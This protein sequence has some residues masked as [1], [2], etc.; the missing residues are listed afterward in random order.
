MIVDFNR[1][2]ALGGVAV[3][4]LVAAGVA[5]PVWAQDAKAPKKEAMEE[6]VV[7]GS[8]IKRPNLTQPVPVQVFTAEAIKA[9]GLSS[10]IDVIAQLP[11]GQNN[12]TSAVST[13]FINGAGVNF[14]N[15]RGLGE[16]R[17]LT[18][19]DGKRHVGSLGGRNN[20]GGTSLVDLNAIAPSMI[21]RIDIVTGGTSAVY[22][23]DAVAG[24][25]NVILKKNF[26]G[27]ELTVQHNQSERAGFESTD[28]N[29]IIGTNFA[30][31]RGNITFAFDRN[32]DSGL[33]G[34]DRDQAL[35]NYT[36]VAN[37][38]NTG[39][40][41]GIPDRITIAPT[42]SSVLAAS[43]SPVIKT[44]IG[45]IA[46][47]TLAFKTDGSGLIPFNRG[48]L[49]NPPTSATSAGDTNSLGGDGYN[50]SQYLTLR[51][52][53]LRQIGQVKADYEI[54]R[55][56]GPLQ[57]IN[58]FA[59]AKF[60]DSEGFTRSTP[61]ANGTGTPGTGTNLTS[62]T[63]ALQISSDNPYI[64]SDLSALLAANKLTSFQM[65][66]VNADWGGA[67][68][69]SFEY[70]VARVVTGFNGEL[71]NGWKW[72]AFYNYG[73]NRT[74]FI[75]T[76][77][78]QVNLVQ[79]LDAIKLADGSIVCRDTTARA[80]GCVP[81]NPFKVGPLT[82]AQYN[83]SYVFTKEQ[84][85]LTQEDV[86]FNFSGDLLTYSTLFSGTKAPIGFAAGF[87]RRKETTNDKTDPLANQPTGFIYGNQNGSVVGQYAVN[88]G[89][90]ELSVPLL[91]DLPFVK[92]LDLDLA[93]RY[94][95]YTTAGPSST[96]N[97]QGGWAVNDSVKFRS[98]LARAVRAPNIDDLFSPAG[99]NFLGVSDPCSIEQINSGGAAR[100]ANCKAVVP[101]GYKSTDF[102]NPSVRTG[103]NPAL[104]PEIGTTFTAG[105]VLTPSF[106]PGLSATLDYWLVKIRNGQASLDPNSILRNCYDSGV[107]AQCGLIQR[108]ADG[109]IFR[110]NGTTVNIGR[111]KVTGYD[112]GVTY[113]FNLDRFGL[114]YIGDFRAGFDGSYVPQSYVLQN[115]AQLTSKLYRAGT[116]GYP[117]LKGN[118]RLNWEKGDL[119]VTYSGRFIGESQMF[120]NAAPDVADFSKVPEYWYHDISAKYRWRMVTFFG[121]INNL[122]DKMPPALPFLYQ[123]S[124]QGGSYSTFPV[125]TGAG[126]SYD[127]V[128]R[129]F[130]FG[131]TVKY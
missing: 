43:G 47:Y 104:K 8:R 49:I 72:E 111:E 107:A 42:V 70:Q 108:R 59:D 5:G 69:Y 25:V 85:V 79:Q 1:W 17:T 125:T 93:Y 81:I 60:S 22:G 39:A 115:P 80:L 21:D 16:Y 6:I 14:V 27:A 31:D 116:A 114:G 36:L 82:Q 15:L 98:G 56:I 86:G 94:S 124:Y 113:A 11:Q 45:N 4:A 78:L 35:Y 65:T 109:S 126:G 100:L 33:F 89:F 54:A 51:T 95:S 68:Q 97:V 30:N 123:G 13:R 117:K 29:G 110:I 48:T 73:R 77:R 61:M 106:V 18:V 34:K 127:I 129:T 7:T 19:V 71:K 64:P 2:R 58:F 91:R 57:S 103:G 112:L 122:A 37:P 23:A 90:G 63:G 20:S 119:A 99:D 66:R 32:D 87:E 101:T 12:M 46:Q 62:A 102:S 38:K 88:E 40:N 53:V 75:N 9:T 76:D 83:Y 121:G 52:P 55:N 3:G 120:P 84:A 130:F 67:R 50:P 41:D 105:V 96:W 131:A 74:D 28:I 10:T 92:A 26:E 44:K 118:V 24:V 128:G